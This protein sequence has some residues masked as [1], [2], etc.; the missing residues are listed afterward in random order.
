MVEF[1]LADWLTL[2]QTVAII[3]TLIMTLY[4][5]RRQLRGMTVDVETRVL[6]DLEEKRHRVSEL[7]IDKPELIRVVA[8]P[9]SGSSPEHVVSYYVSLICSHA[10][11]M[12]ER[13]IIS[14]NEWIGWLQWIKNSFAQGTIRKDW[15][16]LKLGSWFDPRFR[17][18]IDNEIIASM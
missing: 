13:K 11:H 12:R 7:F 8:D 14:D 15:I 3:G 10:Y 9:T 17:D 16:E 2:A 4:F 1:G 6:N 5:S 18:F